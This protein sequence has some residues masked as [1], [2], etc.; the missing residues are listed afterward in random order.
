MTS[1]RNP[2]YTIR[3]CTSFADFAA[4]IALQRDV[5]QFSDLDITPMRS[6]VITKHSGGQTVGAFEQSGK[7]L[8]FAHMLPAFD[9]QLRPY[10]Y[11]HMLAVEPEFRNAGLGMKLKLAQRRRALE[12]GVPLI[13]WTFDP[14]QSRNAY[15]NIV[16]LGGVIRSYRTNYY[17]NV[18]TSALHQGLD[19]DRLFIEWWVGSGRVQSVVEQGKLINT[20]APEST[21]EI[22]F[23]IEAI[24]AHNL[25]EARQW[26]LKIRSA[27]QQLLDEGLYCAGFERGKSGEPSK[28]LF[29]KDTRAE[30]TY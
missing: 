13:I 6:F 30:V 29:Y 21:I 12:R 19:T 10:F 28:Y 22:P 16:K 4:C 14:L 9:E 2:E 3:D 8:G 7:L 26:Q 1:E 24:K 15:L 18:S 11:S 23:D 5:W 17:G 25:E 20:T 27:F